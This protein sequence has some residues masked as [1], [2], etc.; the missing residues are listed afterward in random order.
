MPVAFLRLK[1]AA[2]SN[3]KLIFTNLMCQLKV[4]QLR[5][6][7]HALKQ[8]KARGADGITKAMYEEKLEENLLDL[9]SR[10]HRGSYHPSPARQVLIP[11]A[12][13]KMRPLA[14][15]NFEDKIAQKAVANILESLYEPLFV[16]QSLGF[17]PRRGAHTALK[18]VYQLSDDGSRPCVIDADIQK[19]FDSVDHSLLIQTL[20]KKIGDPRF[21]RLIKKMLKVGIL[22]QGGLEPHDLGTPQGSIVS[23]VLANI[24]LHEVLDLWFKENHSSYSQQMIRYADDVIF[25]FK[26]RSKAKEFMGSLKERMEQFKLTLHETKTKLIHFSPKSHETFNFLGFTFYWGKNRKRQALLKLKTQTAK[27]NRSILSFK[28]WIQSARNKY[29]LKDLWKMA[30]SKIRGHYAYYGI[31]LNS[32]VGLFYGQCLLLLF[33]WLNR[34]SQKA[35]WNWNEFKR[36]LASHPLPKPFHLYFKDLSQRELVYV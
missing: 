20:E 35:S 16:D 31:R 21:L 27:L 11:K 25:L 6:A 19:F 8:D 10:I 5:W 1:L 4:D 3:T 34:R 18:R 9:Q 28:E 30:A 14:I 36:R 22:T 33:K 15:S 23:P 32:K 17:R 24:F 29:K 7:F 12:D 13:G 26:N 2:K